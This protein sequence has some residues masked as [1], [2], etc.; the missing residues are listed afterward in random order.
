M[1]NKP[2]ACLV[3]GGV[4]SYGIGICDGCDKEIFEDNQMDALGFNLP[5]RNGLIL[6]ANAAEKLAK[7]AVGIRLLAIRRDNVRQLRMRLTGMSERAEQTPFNEPMFFS[8]TTFVQFEKH[9]SDVTLCAPDSEECS[10]LECCDIS[11]INGLG[12][13]YFEVLERHLT[14]DQ[15]MAEFPLF[16]HSTHYIWDKFT[17]SPKATP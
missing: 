10:I 6:T 13:Q 17:V 12:E 5:I 16:Q 2:T 14:R 11:P 1:T 8:W 7:L 3:C 9:L 4:D 15:L